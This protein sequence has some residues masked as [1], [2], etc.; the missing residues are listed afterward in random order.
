MEI[1]LSPLQT[2][3]GVFD[4]SSIR[5]VTERKQVETEPR[6]DRG[7]NR[8]AQ[9]AA[10]ARGATWCWKAKSPPQHCPGAA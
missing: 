3:G 6:R 8:L 1:S 4:L 5:D 9:E 10:R 2:E 7:G